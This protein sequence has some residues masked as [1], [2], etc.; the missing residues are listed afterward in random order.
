MGTLRMW[1][2]IGWRRKAFKR[3]FPIF[4][5]TSQIKIVTSLRNINRVLIELPAFNLDN[6][7]FVDLPRMHH[8]E[9]ATDTH[10][11]D[12]QDA[13]PVEIDRGDVHAVWPET[14]EEGPDR[15]QERGDVDREAPL[16]QGPA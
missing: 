9:H 11:A 14:P 1:L 8:V 16:A 10:Q 5:H 4:G 13:C 15:V 6:R 12:E 2:L 3:H 7:P